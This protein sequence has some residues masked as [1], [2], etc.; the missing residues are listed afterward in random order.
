MNAENFSS[1]LQDSSK[2]YQIP[3]QELK[4]LVVQYPYCQPLRVLLLQ[5]SQMEQHPDY[6]RNLQMAATYLPDRRFLL[7]LIREFKALDAGESLFELEEERLELKALS[8]IF[9]EREALEKAVAETAPPPAPEETEEEEAFLPAWNWTPPATEPPPAPTPAA[10]VQTPDP[11]PAEQPAKPRPAPAPKAQFSSWQARTLQERSLALEQIAS[12][13]APP[14]K[15]ETPVEEKREE[16]EKKPVQAQDLARKSVEEK[17]DILSETLAGILA[18]QGHSQKAIQM[19][20][21]L[22][23]IFPEKSSFFAQKIELLK[24]K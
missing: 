3:Y 8:E 9:A 4:S 13:P 2:L 14:K 23:L 22:S 20:E 19:Y 12:P 5:K 1:F 16:E 24:R 7:L 10:P 15:R 21:K 11:P 17:D 18:R 6:E